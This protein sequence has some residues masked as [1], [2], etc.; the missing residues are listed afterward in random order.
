MNLNGVVIISEPDFIRLLTNGRADSAAPSKRAEAAGFVALS[1][2][3][4]A[5]G[6]E[7]A[8]EFGAHVE[9]E[10]FL[11]ARDPA[12]TQ[13]GTIQSKSFYFSAVRLSGRV[14]WAVSNVSLL[15]TNT[16]DQDLANSLQGCSPLSK[17][18]TGLPFDIILNLES[19]LRPT[20]A[21]SQLIELRLFGDTNGETENRFVCAGTVRVGEAPSNQPRNVA[22]LPT[23]KSAIKLPEDA[24]VISEADF[25]R[26]L[27]ERN[28]VSVSE[29]A[30]LT[31]A[32]VIAAANEPSALGIQARLVE[33]RQ[34]SSSLIVVARNPTVNGTTLSATQF[35]LAPGDFVGRAQWVGEIAALGFSGEI[36]SFD[37][38]VA[39]CGSLTLRVREPNC[40]S[41]MCIG[42][43]HPWIGLRGRFD[44]GNL[45]IGGGFGLGNLTIGGGFDLGNPTIG[46]GFGLG[47]PT[48]RGGFDTGNP[49]T[50]RDFPTI[51]LFE[52][53]NGRWDIN[54][55]ACTQF[56][57]PPE[58]EETG[59]ACTGIATEICNGRDDNCN[60]LVDEGGVCEYL[61][62]NCPAQPRTCGSITCG[63]IP[64]GVGGVRHCGGPCQ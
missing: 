4:S 63:D 8:I 64:D 32:R 22:S 53:V 5:L 7:G 49:A 46:G 30:K 38:D 9:G 55:I 14:S 60:G 52:R 40:R 50:N 62:M 54:A 61:P 20:N 16:P 47:N 33:G 23:F 51:R 31:A 35:Y 6:V 59:S 15:F 19:G 17:G 56:L 44:I 37:F 58:R 39:P 45:T 28:N 24:V 48:M 10:V 26:I 1:N 13:R 18:A 11:I 27:G 42:G 3:K 21:S 41:D 43:Q 12:I 57:P 2:S 34:F 36:P 25:Y 29:K